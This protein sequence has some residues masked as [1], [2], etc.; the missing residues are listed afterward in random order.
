MKFLSV[1]ILILAASSGCCRCKCEQKAEPNIVVNPEL[2]KEAVII[3]RRML[4]LRF[5]DIKCGEEAKAHAGQIWVSEGTGKAYLY[6]NSEVLGGGTITIKRNHSG[7]DITV[8]DGVIFSRVG[9]SLCTG[10]IPVTSS[11][12]KSN[13]CF[14][15][16][17][18]PWTATPGNVGLGR[19]PPKRQPKSC[20]RFL[21]AWPAC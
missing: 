7:F 19:S 16:N 15:H 3:P 12:W 14:R 4:K 2:P 18:S 11:S 17:P 5:K 13:P 8:P 10:E 21:A 6:R 1:A 20:L 9:E